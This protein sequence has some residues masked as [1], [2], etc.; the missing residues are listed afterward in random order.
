MSESVKSFTDE[1]DAVQHA[2]AGEDVEDVFEDQL[3]TREE[4]KRE[5]E[6]RI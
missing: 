5:E 4:A 2:E 3:Q 1:E 6:T